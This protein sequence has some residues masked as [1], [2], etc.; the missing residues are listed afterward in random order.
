MWLI[1]S[2]TGVLA[3]EAYLEHVL[4]KRRAYYEYIDKL[5]AFAQKAELMHALDDALDKFEALMH[6]VQAH[7]IEFEDST[8]V[9][10]AHFMST[11]R[12]TWAT[13]AG[14]P[15]VRFPRGSS[16]WPFAPDGKVKL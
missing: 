7:G 12:K 16:K 11:H 10:V 6:A 4:W 3:A 15:P 5:H 14:T 2:L 1:L 13:H 9:N 8:Y